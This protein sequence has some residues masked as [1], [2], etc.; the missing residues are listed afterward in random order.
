MI[1]ELY[2]NQ[3]S[4]MG[5]QIK[6]EKPFKSKSG[7]EFT[8]AYSMVSN[9]NIDVYNKQ[10]SVVLSIFPNKSIRDSGEGIP[11]TRLFVIKNTVDEY[12]NELNLFDDFFSD[13]VMK[14]E[15]K[16]ISEKAYDFLTQLPE[17]TD[18]WQLGEV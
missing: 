6:P 12:E 1:I 3:E 5:L 8:E 11:E 4:L 15:G 10:V 14:S 2:F 18:C 16:T 17:I 7:L 13:V 9:A